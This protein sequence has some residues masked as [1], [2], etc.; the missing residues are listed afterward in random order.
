MIQIN[1]KWHYHF[2]KVFI[3]NPQPSCGFFQWFI[4]SSVNIS[5]F[6]FLGIIFISLW[7]AAMSLIYSQL[8]LALICDESLLCLPRK[9]VPLVCLTNNLLQNGEKKEEENIPVFIH[10]SDFL[11]I[12]MWLISNA[13]TGQKVQI[14]LKIINNWGTQRAGSEE[15]NRGKRASGGSTLI[16]HSVYTCVTA[17]ENGAEAK[18]LS[19]SLFYNVT[20]KN[21]CPPEQSHSSF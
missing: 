14:S 5:L 19:K 1:K 21:T 17:S 15:K 20:L 12:I 4:V 16:D 3:Y 2:Q 13:D 11:T 8:I 10:F 7:P 6:V 18:A 9:T